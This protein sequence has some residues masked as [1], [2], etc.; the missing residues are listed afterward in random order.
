MEDRGWRLEDAV[1]MRL[2]V[3][4]VEDCEVKEYTL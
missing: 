2:D 3:R 1:G 4:L